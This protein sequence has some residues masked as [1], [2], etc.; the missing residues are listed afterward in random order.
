MRFFKNRAQT[1]GSY[2][3]R[4]ELNHPKNAKLESIYTLQV[5]IYNM[6]Q[7]KILFVGLLGLLLIIVSFFVTFPAKQAILIMNGTA[8]NLEI[9]EIR[10]IYQSSRTNG[11]Y[12]YEFSDETWEEIPIECVS[13]G[14][15]FYSCEDGIPIEICS[16]PGPLI[17]NK[18]DN[19]VSFNWDLT[20]CV[21]TEKYCGIKEY[22]EG[23]MNKV[24]PGVYKAKFCYYLDNECSGEQKCIE[25]EFMIN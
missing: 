20:K 3:F 14:C 23:S 15:R 8:I 4:F 12:I 21:T 25:K 13:F 6:I 17:C 5:I 2:G 16:D 7:K 10:P 22:L 19:N 1:F 24:N 9:N 18:I 11:W